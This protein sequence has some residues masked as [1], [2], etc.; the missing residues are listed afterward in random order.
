MFVIIGV[1][2][3]VKCLE[4]RQVRLIRLV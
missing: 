2:N 3:W 1:E 4:I